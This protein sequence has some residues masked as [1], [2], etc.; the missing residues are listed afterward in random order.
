M[1][2]NKK[3]TVAFS[4]MA[5]CIILLIAVQFIPDGKVVPA[6]AETE[7]SKVTV[8]L[9]AVGDNLI[10]SPIFNSCK[11]EN[12]FNFDGLYKNIKGY[13]K[14][15]DIAAINQETIF[16]ED[17]SRFS[18]YP[19]FGTP[20]QVGESIVRAGFNTVTHATNHTYDKGENAVLYTMD[21]WDKH[22]DVMVLGIN[23]TPEKKQQ[24]A[25]FEKNGLKIAMLNFTYG[26]N[27]YKL[28]K[29]KEH[30]VNI[31][32]RSE[33][34]ALLLKKAEDDADITVVFTH[35][36]T[37]YTHTPTKE[38]KKDV[39]FLCKNGADVIIGTHPHVVQPFT[40]HISENGNE[41][42]VFYSLG[43]FISNQDGPSKILGAMAD[44]TIT[45]EN[46]AAKVEKYTMHPTVT[47][48]SDK[49]Y[50]AYMLY[51]YTD[52]LAKTHSRAYGLTVDKLKKLYDEI[53]NIEV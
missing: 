17:S 10:H 28:L 36:G 14:D 13:I 52:E 43:N 31:F 48:V 44:V 32:S 18:G 53:I 25:I 15:A 23:R 50:T 5:L 2:N 1:K 7:N 16:V 41:A 47:H 35:F 30:L 26:L 42:V 49:K 34:T 21:F 11:T 3:L 27:G 46:G 19:A 39:E 45:K 37:E 20:P 33:E 12:G 6:V 38:Q 4:V 22:S 51:D 8:R 29:E 24:I 40:K 9:L